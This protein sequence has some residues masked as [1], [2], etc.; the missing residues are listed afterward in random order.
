MSHDRADR[1]RIKNRVPSMSFF[2]LL[3][4]I[5]MVMWG[6]WRIGLR[7][8]EMDRAHDER[9]SLRCRIEQDPNNLAAY[10]ALG[11]NL[12][13]ARRYTH[14]VAAYRDALA[15]I[16]DESGDFKAGYQLKY[17]IKQIEDTPTQQS[18]MTAWLTAHQK[19]NEV[20]FC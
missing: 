11:D 1:L 12:L 20:V 15:L 18:R 14:A 7:K 10:E 2:L 6:W 5:G 13:R 19:Q 8:R 16:N 17:K 9:E 4:T 3:A